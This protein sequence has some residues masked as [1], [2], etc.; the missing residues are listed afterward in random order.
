MEVLTEGLVFD[1]VPSDSNT[2][3]KPAAGQ[4]CDIGCLPCHER[5]LTL[6]KD[7]DA[8]GELDSLGHRSQIREHHKRVV[9]R[10]TIGIGPDQRGG[11]LGLHG[12]EHMLVSE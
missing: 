12:S 7:Q 10:I 6:R 8:G 1:M 11:S 3:S 9:E 5:R 4:Q 2:E